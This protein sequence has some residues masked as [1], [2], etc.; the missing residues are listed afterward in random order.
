MDRDVVATMNISY[1]VM[2]RFCIPKGDTNEAMV[3]ECG[4]KEPLVLKV[5]VS[6]LLVA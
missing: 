6:K 4:R 5:D 2:Q 1:K 3:Q